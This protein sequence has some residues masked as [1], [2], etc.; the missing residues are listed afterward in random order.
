[1]PMRRLLIHLVRFYRLAISPMMAPRCRFLP[2]CSDYAIE[3]IERH[4]PIKGGALALRRILR[5]H[6]WG[7][8]GFDPVPVSGSE[9]TTKSR[10]CC[11]PQEGGRA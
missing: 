7:G 1:M 9:I 6:P 5:C 10:P 8:S 11:G 4:G 3:A 2:T